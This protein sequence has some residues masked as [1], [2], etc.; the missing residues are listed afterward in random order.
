M[1]N[2]WGSN[3]I[4]L[5]AFH[6]YTTDHAG[7]DPRFIDQSSDG[8]GHVVAWSWDFGDGGTSNLQSPS[9]HYAAAGTYNVS[10]TVTDDLGATAT[11]QGTLKA[12]HHS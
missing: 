9:H 1:K 12:V 6:I 11:H 5:N 8:D 7:T 2:N 10:L 3:L 4:A